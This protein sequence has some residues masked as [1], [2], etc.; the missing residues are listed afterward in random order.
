MFNWFSLDF[1]YYP[2]SGIMWLWYKLFAAA[3]WARELL[4]LG[5]VGD[6]PGVHSASPALQAVRSPN[7]DHPS[8]AG[9]PAADQGAAEEVRQR[10]PADGAGDA[11]AATRARLQS[12]PRLPADA[13][14]DPGVPRP[15]SRADVV[16]PHPDWLRQARAFG[17]GEPLAAELFFSADRRQP[18]PGR[19]PVRRPIGAAITQQHGLEAFTVFSRPAV[20]A[21]GV[22]LMILAGIA[23][24]F[25]SRASIAR[26]ARRPRPTR[27]PR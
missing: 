7:P 5:A 23:T 1:V 16:Q 9:T 4:C 19:Q 25:N 6:V 14:A 11:E 20:A 2:V 24:Y 22:P 21:V 27:R 17:R 12:H 3:S 15:L 13:G 18:F 8:D 10:P 26:Q